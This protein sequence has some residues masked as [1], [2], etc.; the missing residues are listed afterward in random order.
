MQKPSLR[1]EAATSTSRL[2][3][4]WP[5][6]P[7]NNVRPAHLRRIYLIFLG[8]EGLLDGPAQISEQ[9]R[10]IWRSGAADDRSDRARR[11]AARAAG[12]SCRTQPEA[13]RRGRPTTATASQIY[14]P[15]GSGGRARPGPTA[16][17]VRDGSHPILS[18]AR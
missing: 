12:R 5:Q 16:A 8:F 11:S 9:S 17:I 14:D 18:P 10:S 15:P 2:P 4:D 7:S 1:A 3:L 6:L 13:S